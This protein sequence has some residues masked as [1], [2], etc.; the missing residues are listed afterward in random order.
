M[1]WWS[2]LVA[3]PTA[4]G[5]ITYYRA[6]T[7]RHGSVFQA[8]RLLGP[9]LVARRRGLI[10]GVAPRASAAVVAAARIGIAACMILRMGYE[11]I[12]FS[13]PLDFSARALPYGSRTT[14]PSP[15]A[16]SCVDLDDLA[17]SR[18]GPERRGA[19]AA[20]AA[21]RPTCRQEIGVL[22]NQDVGLRA[23]GARD[24]DRDTPGPTTRSRREPGQ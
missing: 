2:I 10:L 18:A 4:G 21:P 1:R 20:R 15:A 3:H 11:W 19:E 8:W 14:R 13:V 6:R 23:T 7:R 17:P 24:V 12:G 9:R 22:L 5:P 16:A